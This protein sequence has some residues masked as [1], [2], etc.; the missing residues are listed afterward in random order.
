MWPACRFPQHLGQ[1]HSPCGCSANLRLG[2]LGN[3]KMWWGCVSTKSSITW[4]ITSWSWQSW[5]PPIAKS[6]I[7]SLDVQAHQ[8]DC[9]MRP[10]QHEKKSERV[11]GRNFSVSILG[12]W[13]GTNAH[14]H[15]S[16]GAQF[17]NHLLYISLYKVL[18]PELSLCIAA[19]NTR[20]CSCWKVF[21]PHPA[22]RRRCA[23]LGLQLCRSWGVQCV[24]SG[25][26]PTFCAWGHLARLPRLQGLAD[27]LRGIPM[28]IPDVSGEEEERERR[29][30]PLAKAWE[31][32]PSLRHA[33]KNYQLVFWLH[34]S[35]RQ[36]CGCVIFFLWVCR[37]PSIT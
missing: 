24:S 19:S 14:E 2:M 18:G 21:T 4:A 20:T 28:V 34:V 37:E 3:G 29:A 30:T 13:H 36:N 26:A 25:P 1:L 12:D 32:V 23:D 33:A 15:E 9:R 17:I 16:L 27:S 7:Q 6:A 11:E 8:L 22:K 5:G 10:W 31:K 35:W